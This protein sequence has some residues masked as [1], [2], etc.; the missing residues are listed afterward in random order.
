MWLSSC[1]GQY[2]IR[3]VKTV[4]KVSKNHTFRI[5][6]MIVWEVLWIKPVFYHLKC[7]LSQLQGDK[8]YTGDRVTSLQ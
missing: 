8:F 1:H 5:A 4:L 2:K 3:F 7:Q 6:L